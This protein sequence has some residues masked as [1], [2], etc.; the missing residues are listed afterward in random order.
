MKLNE[1]KSGNKFHDSEIENAKDLE[2]RIVEDHM[3]IITNFKNL[4]LASDEGNGN[5]FVLET[6]T[7]QS[8]HE[9]EKFFISRFLRKN[10][11]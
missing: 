3:Y 10:D 2:F 5:G 6:Y 11:S 1:L 7:F 9:F 8:R 4:I